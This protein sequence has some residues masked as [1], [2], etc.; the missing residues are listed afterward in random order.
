MIRGISRNTID[1]LGSPVIILETM[2]TGSNRPRERTVKYEG[3][4]V[5]IRGISRNTIDN[6]GSPVIILETMEGSVWCFISADM[7]PIFDKKKGLLW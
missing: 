5:V 3:K 6:L 2:C 7:K 4:I 1:N